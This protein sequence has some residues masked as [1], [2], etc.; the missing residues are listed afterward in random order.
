MENIHLAQAGLNLLKNDVIGV[1]KHRATGIYELVLKVNES[2]EVIDTVFIS[3]FG[4]IQRGFSVP[5]Q[6][7]NLKLFP[8]NKNMNDILENPFKWDEFIREL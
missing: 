2:S 1:F 6:S 4:A 7:G 3:Q 5:Y 8:D